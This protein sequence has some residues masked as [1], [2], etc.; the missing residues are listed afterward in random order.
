M[1]EPAISLRIAVKDAANGCLSLGTE[2]A[3]ALTKIEAAAPAASQSLQ[4]VDRSAGVLRS[5]IGNVAFKSK[6]S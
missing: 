1:A 4:Q 5:E 2:G 6:I 3:A